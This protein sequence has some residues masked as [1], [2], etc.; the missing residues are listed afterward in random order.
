MDILNND[1]SIR[2]GDITDLE[3]IVDNNIKMAQETENKKL[4]QSAIYNGVDELLNNSNLGWYYI[5]EID[6]HIA[7]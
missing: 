4:C 2:K 6:R 7:R 3:D 1:I 5:A